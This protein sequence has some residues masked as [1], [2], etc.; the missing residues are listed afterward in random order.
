MSIDRGVE[1]EDVAQTNEIMPFAA[2]QVDLEMI[3][4][5]EVRQ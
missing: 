4:L 1:E 2:T 5:N 3:R